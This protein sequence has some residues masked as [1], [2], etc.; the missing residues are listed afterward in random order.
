MLM[1][2]S[3]SCLIHDVYQLMASQAKAICK[4]KFGH[5]NYINA[6]SF[7]VI[8]LWTYVNGYLSMEKVHKNYINI[9][10]H[11]FSQVLFPT[12][13]KTVKFCFFIEKFVISGPIKNLTEIFWV[14]MIFL[15]AIVFFI[16]F[17]LI[18]VIFKKTRTYFNEILVEKLN[19]N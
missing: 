16:F 8:L 10:S 4:S 13:S 1:P 5:G 18:K 11:H 7:S 12:M 9:K 17:F 6:S 3:E 14:K 15:K 19:K 2:S